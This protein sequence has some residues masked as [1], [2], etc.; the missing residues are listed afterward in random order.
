MSEFYALV[1]AAGSGSRM[2]SELPKQYLPLAGHPM[3]Y[4]ALTIL[5]A[6]PKISQ[7]FVVLATD[8][9][10][11]K[12]YD[13]SQCAEKLVPLYCGGATRAESVANG[14]LASGVEAE[15][16]LLVH[17]AARPCLTQDNLSNIINELENDAVG[18]IL[19][20]P[21]ADTLKRADLHHRI[22]D[23]PSREKLWQAQTPQMFRA[24]LLAHAL[25]QCR[26]VTDEAS[27]V[28]ALGLQPKLVLGDSRNFKV[29]YPQDQ[30]LAELLLQS[31]YEI[32]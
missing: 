30:Q 4:Y 22:I 11:F 21:V 28:E 15:D 16:W 13:W 8:D 7:V 27:A 12:G 14:I 20:I 17:D 32:L 2:Q 3:L 9:L 26:Q 6:C 1:P 19:A 5:C 31:R 10:H 24:G 23:T 18:G 25:Q 29:T